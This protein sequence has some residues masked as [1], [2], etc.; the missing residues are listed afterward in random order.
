MLLLFKTPLS[1]CWEQISVSRYPSEHSLGRCLLPSP[2][3]CTG[4]DPY[5]NQASS[6]DTAQQI[7]RRSGAQTLTPG[8]FS[9]PGARGY[10]D[11]LSSSKNSMFSLFPVFSKHQHCAA[12]SPSELHLPALGGGQASIVHPT[13][14]SP[15]LSS[16][17]ATKES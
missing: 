7:F 5:P 15:L 14:P 12:P 9:I 8:P 11:N 10:T 13:D 6:R 2:T 1:V 3:A 16:F 4:L 17:T